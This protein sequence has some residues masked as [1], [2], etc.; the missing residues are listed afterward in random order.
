MSIRSAAWIAWSLCVLCVALAMASLIFALLNG[1]T[2]GEIFLAWRGEPSIACFAIIAV[3]FSVVGA[4]I[5]SHRPGNPIGWVFCAAAL[6]Q[7]LADAT[8]QYADYALLTNPGSLPL[9]GELSWL[10]AWIWAPGLGLIVVFLPLLFP[11]GRP[12]SRRWRPV[13]WLGGL[14]IGL[15]C[16]LTAIVLWP[17]RGPALV[18]PGSFPEFEGWRYAVE[19]LVNFA[20][21]MLLLAGFGAVISLLVR[22]RRAR[23]D[24][25]Q[26]IKW[27]ASAAALSLVWIFVFTGQVTLGGLPEA[28]VALSSLLV[29]PSIPIATGIA[30]LRYRLYDID[31]I[32]NRTLVYGLLTILLA[33]GYVATIMAL[34]GIGDLVFQLPFRAV[35]GQKST[36]ATI[37]ATLAMAALFNPLRHRIQSFIDRRFYR[38]KYDARKTLEAFSAKLRDETD[39]DALSEDLTSVVRETLQ[40]A[41]VSLWLPPNSALKEKKR[42]AIRES[43][44][45]EERAF[46][47]YSPND[48]GEEFPKVH[49]IGE[50]CFQQRPLLL[51]PLRRRS[52]KMSVTQTARTVPATTLPA[53]PEVA[54]SGLGCGVVGLPS[55]RS[56]SV[57]SILAM[58][59]LVAHGIKGAI[60]L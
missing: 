19:G 28:I 41:H 45:D 60:V 59:R 44:R 33:A 56:F 37:A 20:Y 9:G 23:G 43:G 35:F 11:D 29:V 57:R 51:A 58:S 48:L 2:L 47:G 12:P 32:I 38:S 30:I 10:E 55:S 39:L 6:F 46:P 24:E 54:D 4:L 27:F 8:G 42:A 1:R 31:L 16:V 15:I 26:Q 52:R 5:A 36:L 25:R 49:L 17:E 3:S 40:P 21:P 50:R 13:V 14:S 7:V 34:Q 18:R 53:T 22:F